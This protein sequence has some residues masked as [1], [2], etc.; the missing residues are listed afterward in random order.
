[1]RVFYLIPPSY[2]LQIFC[3]NINGSGCNSV[4]GK[5]NAKV[6]RNDRFVSRDNR[7]VQ[8]D[9]AIVSK[10][11]AKR[12]WRIGIVESDNLMVSGDN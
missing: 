1:M 9:N 7:F 2:L 6:G 8:A 11:K 12:N 4:V 3:C 10:N 5:N